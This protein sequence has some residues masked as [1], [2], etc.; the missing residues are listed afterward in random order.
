MRMSDDVHDVIRSMSE[1]QVKSKGDIIRE[2][3]EKG[4][5][6]DELKQQVERLK[7]ENNQLNGDKRELKAKATVGN[8]NPIDVEDLKATILNGIN[9]GLNPIKEDIKDHLGSIKSELSIG[10]SSETSDPNIDHTVEHLERCLDCAKKAW[11]LFDKAQSECADCQMPY[12]WDRSV[13]ESSSFK[14]PKCG[15]DE[16]ADRNH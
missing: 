12:P 11:D 15:S 13:I 6:A 9:D 14:C 4:L 8:P 10:G 5:D 2:L 1:D 3:V 7:T 16:A